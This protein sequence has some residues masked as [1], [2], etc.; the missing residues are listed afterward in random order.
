MNAQAN[1]R[2]T[3]LR[4]WLDEYKVSVGCAD[5]GYRANPVALDFDHVGDTKTRNVCA[6]KSM[7]QARAEIELCEVRCANCHRVKTHER[8]HSSA[9]S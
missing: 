1:E 4:R 5:C 7:A 6:S 2:A 3:A 9:G 8:R